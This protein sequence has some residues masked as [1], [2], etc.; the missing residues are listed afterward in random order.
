MNSLILK[1]A[2][3]IIN[4]VLL[5][6]SVYLLLAGHQ[7][8]GGG[9]EAGLLTASAFVFHSLAYD[10]TSA[11][12]KLRVEPHFLIAYGLLLAAGSGFFQMFNK[13]PFM[14]GVWFDV[15][16][17][18]GASFYL[19][20]PVIFDLGVYLVVLGTTLLVFFNLKED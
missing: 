18:P 17:W 13:L 5:I 4:P 3:D 19:G 8:P 7:S 9:F 15:T 6:L 2:A 14:T 11:R 1:K 16:L 10:V 12:R 20:T